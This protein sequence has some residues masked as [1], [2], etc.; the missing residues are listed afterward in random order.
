MI[1]CSEIQISV[2]YTGGAMLHNVLHIALLIS[3]AASQ[4]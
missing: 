2:E 4:G 3:H 1:C